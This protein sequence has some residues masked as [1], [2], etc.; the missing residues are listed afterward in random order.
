M[1]IAAGVVS[2]YGHSHGSRM[3]LQLEPTVVRPVSTPDAPMIEN[4]QDS[5]SDETLRALIAEVELA[6]AM[7]E[8]ARIS[9]DAETARRNYINARHSHDRA[10]QLLPPAA[11]RMTET[12]QAYITTK[13]AGVSQA[14][15]AAS[16]F[17]KIA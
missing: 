11:P 6:V 5:T 8:L 7:I 3:R 10:V 16:R 2:L 9:R 1:R 15:E 17:L 4:A 13:L 14:L 12:T